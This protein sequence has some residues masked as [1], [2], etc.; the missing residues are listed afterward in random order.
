M[1]RLH[2]GKYH[3]CDK[4]RM[5]EPESRT[6]GNDEQEKPCGQ[7]VL[8]SE[9]PSQNGSLQRDAQALENEVGSRQ[10]VSAARREGNDQVVDQPRCQEHQQTGNCCSGFSVRRLKDQVIGELAEAEVPPLAPE[11]AQG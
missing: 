5:K 6:C 2:E 10:A 11:L 1:D 9:V 3:A 8:K 7:S 4:R